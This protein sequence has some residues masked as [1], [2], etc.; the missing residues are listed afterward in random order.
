LQQL[1]SAYGRSMRRSQKQ[2]IKRK[3]KRLRQQISAFLAQMRNFSQLE[4]RSHGGIPWR[5]FDDSNG[6]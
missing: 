5:G 6:N 2:H 1:K 3:R 4:T